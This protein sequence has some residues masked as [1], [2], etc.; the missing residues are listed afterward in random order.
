MERMAQGTVGKLLPYAEL[1]A[2]RLPR[3]ALESVGGRGLGNPPVRPGIEGSAKLTEAV[4]RRTESGDCTSYGG[5][6]GLEGLL[7]SPRFIKAIHV[8]TVHRWTDWLWRLPSSHSG[9]DDFSP[10]FVA[11]RGVSNRARCYGSH[12]VQLIL[13]GTPDDKSQVYGLLAIVRSQC[14]RFD[15]HLVVSVPHGV[16]RNHKERLTALAMVRDRESIFQLFA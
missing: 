1:I 2:L 15:S 12:I 8:L 5:K 16:L 14:R 7:C 10:H 6:G 3:G 11:V 13:D 4:C 9:I